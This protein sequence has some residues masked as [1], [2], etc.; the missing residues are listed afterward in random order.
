MNSKVDKLP[1][2]LKYDE[3][4]LLRKGVYN[5]S[6]TSVYI[7]KNKDFAFLHPHPVV[8]YENYK[9]RVE[10]LNLSKYKKSENI[11]TRRLQKINHLVKHKK[12][13]LEIGSADGAFLNLMHQNFPLLSY[14][15]VEPDISTSIY[16][17]SSYE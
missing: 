2:P 7:N 16:R 5:S 6:E 13:F 15:S 12:S 10:Q 14:Y 1:E 4:K 11:L 9:P 8:D 17:L 3:F